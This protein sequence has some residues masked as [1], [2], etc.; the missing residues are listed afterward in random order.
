[1]KKLLITSARESKR[2]FAD[3]GRNFWTKVV[4]VKLE[5]KSLK[6]RRCDKLHTAA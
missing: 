5:A 6:Q 2:E 3:L 4:D 1:M